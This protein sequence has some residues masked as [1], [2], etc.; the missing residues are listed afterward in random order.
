M[1][2]TMPAWESTKKLTVISYCNGE[3]IQTG[4]KPEN[5]TNSLKKIKLN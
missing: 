4:P 2:I 3:V 5:A 1:A